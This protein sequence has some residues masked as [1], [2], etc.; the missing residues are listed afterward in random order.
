VNSSAEPNP[1]PEAEPPVDFEQLSAA[2]G[3]DPVMLQELITLYFDQARELMAGLETALQTQSAKE[4][5][6]LA[7]KLA[8]A[9]LACGMTA[10]VVPL[11]ALE[12]GGRAGNLAGGQE[13]LAQAAAQLEIVR[14]AVQEHLRAQ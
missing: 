13:F 9:S 12:H 3:D 6:H 8:G 2:S 7:H 5:D 11:R 4:V 1:A 10:M 14:A